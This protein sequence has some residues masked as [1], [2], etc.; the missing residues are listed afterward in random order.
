MF[1]EQESGRL[2]TA[3]GS[4]SRWHVAEVCWPGEA[5]SA[6]SPILPFVGTFLRPLSLGELYG[7]LYPP[8][9][10]SSLP[11]P[12]GQCSSLP[13]CL[14]HSSSPELRPAVQRKE[15]CSEGPDPLWGSSQ[16][17]TRCAETVHTK[18]YQ[19]PGPPHVLGRRPQSLFQ[20]QKNQGPDEEGGMGQGWYTSPG[21]LT[22]RPVLMLI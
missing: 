1:S 7:Q 12:W 6:T 8:L 3:C 15:H 16:Y 4:L 10:R 5:S 11:G 17:S 14:A 22:P 9:Q 21:L 20:R 19:T 18:P 2:R 13:S